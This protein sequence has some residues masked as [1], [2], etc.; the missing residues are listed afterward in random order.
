MAHLLG[1]QCLER[2]PEPRPLTYEEKLIKKKK[3]EDWYFRSTAPVLRAKTLY[4]ELEYNTNFYKKVHFSP[5]MTPPTTN[6]LYSKVQYD[7]SDAEPYDVYPE[8][9]SPDPPKAEIL[10]ST[11]RY[12][13]PS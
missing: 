3:E 13:S 10:Y 4:H 5:E 6:I 1:T 2:D 11:I 7:S 8:T 9:F 12:A